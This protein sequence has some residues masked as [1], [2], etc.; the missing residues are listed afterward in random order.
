MNLRQSLL[1]HE[2]PTHQ[3]HDRDSLMWLISHRPKRLP[4]SLILPKKLV[5]TIQKNKPWDCLEDRWFTNDLI[6]DGMHGFRHVSRVSVLATYLALSRF[7]LSQKELSA[8]MFSCLFH[9][10]RRKNDN[11]DPRHGERAAL[12]L[13]RN[14]D[15][16]PKELQSFLP[17]ICFSIS[18]HNDPYDQLLKTDSYRKFGLFVDVL[19]T[20]D[21]LD[22]Y[23]FPKAD[24]WISE[25][26]IV[27][28]PHD[29]E[30]AFAFD[31]AYQ[32][33]Y[34]F[35][36]TGNSKQAMLRSWNNLSSKK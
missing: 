9:D 15:V 30:M 32:S 1:Q 16:L 19:K 22:R 24:W 23:R 26:F 14:R 3:F 18:V 34:S 2:K 8:I 35:V 33:E 5:E 11:A 36:G 4:K 13:K 25:K 7:S 6:R 27:L 21:A 10:C 20:A 29:K 28:L 31:L 12:W 17:A